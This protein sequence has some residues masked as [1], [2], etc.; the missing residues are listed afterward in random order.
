M[1]PTEQTGVA[2]G[3]QAAF[4]HCLCYNLKF[5]KMFGRLLL[6]L[7]SPDHLVNVRHPGSLLHPLK[8][9]Q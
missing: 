4:F 8:E 2:G 1:G 5:L 6:G 9:K 3:Q 7:E